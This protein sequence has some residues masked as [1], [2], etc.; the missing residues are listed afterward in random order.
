MP[1]AEFLTPEEARAL[2]ERAERHHAEMCARFPKMARF[3]QALTDEQFRHVIELALL[4]ELRRVDSLPPLD[5]DD[6]ADD[7]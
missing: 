2:I 1:D 6:D 7:E 5:D 4:G 3:F